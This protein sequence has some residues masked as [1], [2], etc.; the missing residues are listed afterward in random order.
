MILFN[1]VIDTTEKG[2]GVEKVGEA[3]KTEISP[4]HHV[5]P[6]IPPTLIFHGTSDT[7]VPFENVERF[8]TLMTEAGNHCKL[9]A[10]EGRVHG[11]FNGSFF[12]PEN[13]DED[14]QATMNASLEFLKETGMLQQN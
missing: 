2:Y 4:C 7:T 13:K 1:P 3:R 8:T 6:G 10:F 12:R 14:Y 9:V 11:F 5:R